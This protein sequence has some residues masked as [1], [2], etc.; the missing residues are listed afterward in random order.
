[1]IL[2]TSSFFTSEENEHAHTRHTTK[3]SCDNIN[4][5]YHFLIG[6]KI[7]FHDNDLIIIL[8]L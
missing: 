6:T 5:I 3:K 2:D 1:M 7:T 4:T 8:F